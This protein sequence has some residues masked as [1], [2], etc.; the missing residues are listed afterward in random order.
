MCGWLCLQRADSRCLNGKKTHR[1]CKVIRVGLRRT[2]G[3]W[4][5]AIPGCEVVGKWYEGQF[6]IAFTWVCIWYAATFGFVYGM[7]TLC[8]VLLKRRKGGS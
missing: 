6:L 7:L 2:H 8:S 4:S 5:R 1:I 3:G